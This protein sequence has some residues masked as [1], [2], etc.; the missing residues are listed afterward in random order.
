[1]EFVGSLDLLSS[2]PRSSCV[3]DKPLAGAGKTKL[4]ST[5]IDEYRMQ[6]GEDHDVADEAGVDEDEVVF[7]VEADAGDDFAHG[8]FEFAY[9]YCQRD[10]ESSR[11]SVNILRS[12]IKQLA[13]NV[14]PLPT[15]L[16]RIHRQ[17]GHR[18]ASSRTLEIGECESLLRLFLSR[19][20]T[21]LLILDALD[22]CPAECQDELLDVFKSLMQFDREIRVKIIVSSRDDYSRSALENESVLR[23]S[24]VDNNKDIIALVTTRI[25]QYRASR[26]GRTRPVPLIS[27]DLEVKIIRTFE[28]KSNGM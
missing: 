22:E 5:I 1:M 3:A 19:E 6:K 21:T 2:S 28:E 16:L 17:R 25:A 23:I 13:E 26:R 7:A 10:R 8:N 11:D 12:F 9:F 20:S 14:R 27:E 4:I 18:G 15:E 24:A